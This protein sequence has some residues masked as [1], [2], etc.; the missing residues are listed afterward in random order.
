VVVPPSVTFTEPPPGSKVEPLA[1]PPVVNWSRNVAVAL[2][3]SAPVPV[4]TRVA[5]TSV[6]TKATSSLSA[7][8]VLVPSL[9]SPL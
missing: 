2:L 1:V 4:P 8:D 3:V 7:L 5:T 9:T 6:E